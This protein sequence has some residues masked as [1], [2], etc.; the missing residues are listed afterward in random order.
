MPYRGRRG[1]RNRA[2]HGRRRGIP[3]L[4][5]FCGRH[6]LEAGVKFVAAFDLVS[7][8]LIV[9]MAVTLS[10]NEFSPRRGVVVVPIMGKC[11]K[12]NE[13]RVSGL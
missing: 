11:S 9:V 8:C 4:T 1:G 7:Q 12:Q 2:G 10:V 6:S 5:R 13:D 3:T